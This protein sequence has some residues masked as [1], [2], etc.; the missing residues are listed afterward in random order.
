Q[1]SPP[2]PTVIDG[3]HL[4]ATGAGVPL[5][6]IHGVGLDLEIWELLVPLLQRRRRLIRYDMQGHGASAKPTGPYR[7]DDFVEQ[8][9]RLATALELD[10]FDLAGFSMGGM[11]AEAFTARFPERVRRLALLHTVHDRSATERAAVAARLAQVEADDL[12]GSIEAAL[13]RWLNATFRTSH[14]EAVAVIEQRMRGNDRAA[15]LASYGVFATADPDLLPLLGRIRCPTLVLTGEY[16]TGSTPAM[17]QALAARLADARC[18]IL[19]GLRHLSLIEAPD[20]VAPVL[21]R[22]FAV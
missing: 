22:F 10:R 1:W 3:T 9:A 5:V 7:L 11:V 21:D 4:R 20:V 6:L 12:E 19:P 16:D 13:A 14:P 18:A 15:Y 17:A 2:L 8:L